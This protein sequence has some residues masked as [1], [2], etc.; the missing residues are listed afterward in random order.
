MHPN[1]ER[2]NTMHLNYGYYTLT[3]FNETHTTQ[4]NAL[5]TT[6]WRGEADVSLSATQLNAT[7]H[8]TTQRNALNTTL[9]RGEADVCLSLLL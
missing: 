2:T 9:Y 3:Q 7:H 8:N 5:N 1:L 6:V 4:R